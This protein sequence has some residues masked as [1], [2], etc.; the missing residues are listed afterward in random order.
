[1]QVLVR[2]PVHLAMLSLGKLWIHVMLT[3]GVP[4][5]IAF[6]MLLA[7]WDE[8]DREMY[9]PRNQQRDIR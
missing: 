7:K 6:R 1:M 4:K 5:S 8:I 3:W 9:A 2:W